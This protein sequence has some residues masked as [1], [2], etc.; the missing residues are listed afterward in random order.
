MISRRGFLKSGLA[1]TAVAQAA[2]D[3]AASRRLPNVLWICSDQQRYDTIRALGN[4]HIRTPTL[5]D[6]ASDGVAFTRAYVQ[7]TVC[8]PSRASFLTG[9]YPSTLDVN[10]NGN[11][12]F[13]ERVA[14]RLIS[15]VLAA[16]GYIC[17]MVGKMHLS[18]AQNR[19]EPRVDDGYSFFQWN[20]HPKPEAF[21]PL[22]HNAYQRWLH[23]QGVV[24]DREYRSE[25]LEDWPDAYQPGIA[26]EF[27]Q[28][29][30]C[31]N[32]TIRFITENRD[33]RWLINVNIFDPHG[34]FD[35][36]RE[37]LER[38]DPASMPPPLFR[39]E[40]MESQRR[41]AGVDHQ[42]S[43]PRNPNSYPARHTIAAYYAQIELIDDQLGR[44]LKALDDTGQRS[45]TLVIYTTDHGEMLGDHGLLAKGCRFYEGAVRVPLLISWPDRFRKGAI[46][47]EPVELIDI[48]P[49][50]LDAAG[51][52]IPEHVLG[53]PLTSFLTTGAGGQRE[54]RHVRTEYYDA[55]E[56][57]NATHADMFFE[58]RYKLVV[59]HGNGLGEL[60]DLAEDPDEFHN[61]WSD[62]A[63]RSKKAELME[64]LL[65]AVVLS[66]DRGQPRVGRF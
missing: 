22:E 32:E 17:G 51:L 5:D 31:A 30:W 10:R 36:P 40:E 34:P 52:E 64:R 37:Y 8:T 1:G 38:M 7:S 23:D 9:C 60:Y 20:H 18:A 15:R 2:A 13:P 66:K 33:S 56:L 65:S 29:T 24:W 28:T 21:W 11:A 61:L 46:V 58:G 42:T 57:P 41:F 35:P 50:I 48:V 55:L 14:D 45:D 26:T 59:Y 62:P 44:I 27:H 4:D 54:R 6:L 3:G 43:S 39:E 25:R 53:Q 16:R 49:T 19:V 12:H 63:A 47:E